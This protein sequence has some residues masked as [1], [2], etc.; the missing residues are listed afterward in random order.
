MQNKTLKPRSYTDRLSAVKNGKET[1][2]LKRSFKNVLVLSVMKH[3]YFLLK[4]LIND[5]LVYSYF[6]ILVSGEF[7]IK[8]RF[9]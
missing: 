5:N 3:W 6:V 1:K 2:Y 4:R 7:L 9:K 8:Q